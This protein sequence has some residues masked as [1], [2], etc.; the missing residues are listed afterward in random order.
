MTKSQKGER[1]NG[2]RSAQQK[3]EV[4]G[5]FLQLTFL[6]F[7]GRPSFVELIPLVSALHSGKKEIS[8]KTA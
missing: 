5:V 2:L 7:S 3:I 1:E 6:F 8:K 4:G